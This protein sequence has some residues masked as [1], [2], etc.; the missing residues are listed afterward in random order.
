MIGKIL[1]RL[2]R[3][4]PQVAWEP[5]DEGQ[6]WDLRWAAHLY[7]R[8]AFGFPPLSV[9]ARKDDRSPNPLGRLEDAVR[10]GRRQCVTEVLEGAGTNESQS[11]FDQLLDT[12]G[13]RLA[14]GS[15]T[16]FGGIQMDRLQGWWLY[17]MLTAPH[18][19]QERM[20]L[21]W[22]DHFATSVDKVGQPALMFRQNQLLRKHALGDFGQLT[23]GISHDPAMMIFLDCNTNIAAAPNENF[24]REVMELFTLGVGNYTE[25]DI[26]EA[27]RA[28]TGYSTAGGK[29]FLDQKLHDAGQKTVLGQTGPWNGDDIVRI[30]LQQQ[31]CPKF[32]AAKLY[33]EFVN[34]ETEPPEEILAVLAEAIRLHNF[35]MK[36]VLELILSS[37]LFY[38]EHAYRRRIKSPVE[39]IVGLLQAFSSRVSVDVLVDL[40]ADLGQVVFE[41]PNVA[42]WDGGK[43]WLNSATVLARNN[44]AWAIIGGQDEPFRSSVNLPK[45]LSKHA[46]DQPEKQLTFL[47][48]LLLQGDLPKTSLAELKKFLTVYEGQQDQGHPAAELAH[49][50]LILPE[51][52]LA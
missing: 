2:D 29:F 43:A 47:V 11:Q 3:L 9:E 51:Y 10:R 40:S 6:T 46:G 44:L 32:L 20:T 49:T 28:F 36:P 21:F 17:R 31:A 14:A 8:A 41:P 48:Q 12:V 39:Y 50:L 24:A 16:R 7:R 35:Q 45:F 5:A 19:L 26:R 38:S 37:R 23:L 33:R 42:G 27:A 15:W 1:G 25:K 18:P 4:D 22:H 34:E 30:C 52:Q 13:E